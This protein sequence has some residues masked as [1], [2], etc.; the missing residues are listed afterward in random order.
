MRDHRGQQHSTPCQLYDFVTSS[1][2]RCIMPSP[3]FCES[4]LPRLHGRGAGSAALIFHA[5]SYATAA[6]SI[7]E[8]GLPFQLL[9]QTRSDYRACA[10]LLPCGFLPLTIDLKPS[11]IAAMLLSESVGWFDTI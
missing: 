8:R 11:A 10:R 2:S 1:C 3:C 6:C 4:P 5:S 7:E 9:S